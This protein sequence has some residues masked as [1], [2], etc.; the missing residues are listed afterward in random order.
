MAS[1]AIDMSLD[2]CRELVMDRVASMCAAF[3]GVAKGLDTV[4]D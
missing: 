1:P 3:H 4:R 2:G